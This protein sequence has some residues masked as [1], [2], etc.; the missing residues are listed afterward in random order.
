MMLV[1]IEPDGHVSD[2]TIE[3]SSGSS[4]LDRVTQ[5]CVMAGAFEPTRSG[6][7]TIPSWQR[8]HWNWSNQ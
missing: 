6:W 7:R 3:E 2:T 1:R 4:R 5:A 8:V